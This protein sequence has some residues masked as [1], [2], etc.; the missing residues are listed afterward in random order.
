M[1]YKFK[2]KHNNINSLHI[3]KGKV[4]S[5]TLQ[6]KLTK[7]LSKPLETLLSVK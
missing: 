3:D 7:K 2:A 1:N 6:E 5:Q 4:T